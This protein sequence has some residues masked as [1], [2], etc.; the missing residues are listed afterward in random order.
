MPDRIDSLHVFARV[1]ASG[2]LS[3]ASRALGMSQ[4]MVTKHV[5][6]LETRLGVKLLHRTTHRTTLTEAGRR[7]LETVEPILAELEAADA[8]AAA[9]RVEVSGTLRLNAP[10]SFSVRVLAPVLA[11]LATHH[12][13]LS[14]DLG[15]NDRVVDLV[16]KGWDAAVRI[17]RIRDETLIARRLAPCR[18]M[19]AA[20]PAYLAA[21]G[22]PRTIEALSEHNCLGYTFSSWIGPNRW[23]F[24]ADGSIAAPV[25]G[26]FYA[27][28]GDV[29]L[30]AARAG[31]GIIYQPT[32]IIGDDIRAG[33]LV[34]LP[35]DQPPF[36]LD[37]VFAVYPGG[38]RPLAKVRALVDHLAATFGPEP[39]WDRDLGLG[40]I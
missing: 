30:Q 39:H 11:E 17:G 13:D 38:R 32:F 28:N 34:P 35:L 15:L 8:A 20:A 27:N 21:H 23:L 24:A 12:P 31:R 37:G 2:G 1:A 5:V 26:T 3:A 10:V 7:Y 19:V 29:L 18:L 6:A 14:I 16:D 33:K 25:A 4:S 22:V 36:E 40:D 9:E